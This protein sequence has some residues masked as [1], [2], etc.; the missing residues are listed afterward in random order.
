MKPANR[1]SD[2][3]L[4]V[5][6]ASSDRVYTKS[7]IDLFNHEG[8]SSFSV[9]LSRAVNRAD[10]ADIDVLVLDISGLAIDEVELVVRLQR[11]EPLIEVVAIA[12]DSPVADA[13][14][15]LRSGVFTV[16]QHPVPTAGLLDAI[17][18]AGRRHRRAWV[19]L[20]ELNDGRRADVSHVSRR[21][22]FSKDETNEETS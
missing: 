22:S 2:P 11:F 1:S 19:R 21:G 15:A 6:I 18:Q 14:K 16:L 20:A 3:P 9:D 4:V 12:G 13:V 10:L 8:F 7:L 5:A 17:I